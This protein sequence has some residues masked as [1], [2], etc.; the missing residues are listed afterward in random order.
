MTPKQFQKTVWE[1]YKKHGRVL[2]WR[3]TDG[4]EL[5]AYKILVSEYMLQ[6]TQ[7]DRVIPKYQAFL[8]RFPTIVKLAESSNADVLSLWSGLGYNRR[9]LFLKRAAEKIVH[10]YGKK[11]P[12]STETLQT[13]PGIGSYTAGAIMSFAWNTPSVCIETNI[14][15]VYIHHFFADRE[16]KV[17]DQELLSVIQ[18]TCDIQ[19]PREWYWAL[20]D[21]GAYLKSQGVKTHRKSGSYAKQKAF[22][23]SLREVRGAILKILTKNPRISL[24]KLYTQLP[25]DIERT[26]RALGDLK[27]EGI[28]VEER[29][30]VRIC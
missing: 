30:H 9:A 8:K 12:R 2:P 16:E 28:L 4:T 6:Q 5:S 24:V 1:Y 25:F 22:K 19:N 14:R 10:E 3:L 11:I 23:G 15:T 26:E 17:S 29:K 13:L 7:V 18:K 27:K 20:M 21:Y